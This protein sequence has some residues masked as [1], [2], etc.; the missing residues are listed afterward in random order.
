MRKEESNVSSDMLFQ[1]M[2]AAFPDESYPRD[3]EAVPSLMDG[4]SFF[5]AGRGLYQPNGST[6]IPTFPFEGVMIVGRDFGTLDAYK[7]A[8]ASDDHGELESDPTWK[9]LLALLDAADCD[10]RSCFFSNAFMGLRK[11]KRN[12]GDTQAHRDRNFLAACRDFFVTQIEM[13][14]PRVLLTL[15]SAVP[16]FVAEKLEVDPSWCAGT[17]KAIDAANK[18]VQKDV[19]VPDLGFT[20]AA[21]VAL[22]H[23]C[24][25]PVNVRRRSYDLLPSHGGEKKLRGHEAERMMLRDALTHAGLLPAVRGESR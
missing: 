19:A 10:P 18:P 15:G 2:R 9:H 25:R 13:M 14:R 1:R 5:P 4:L 20:V 7:K 17:L 3:L 8:K 24:L 21:T 16:A 22:T 6:E 11:G 12:V 23:P